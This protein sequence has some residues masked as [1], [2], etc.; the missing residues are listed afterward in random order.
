MLAV[1]T[2]QDD[3]TVCKAARMFEVS[4]ETL[5][6]LVIKDSHVWFGGGR[7]PVLTKDEK[8]LIVVAL[9]KFG[10]KDWPC[11]R[12]DLKLNV[13]NYLDS[14]GKQTRFKNNLPG[15]D[16]FASFRKRCQHRLT[17]RKPEI[18]T[19]GRAK[20]L[21]NKVVKSFF[22]MVEAATVDTGIFVRRL[23]LLKIA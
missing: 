17:V 18:L 3:Q 15:E 21:T 12:S 6:R 20:G 10:K 16:W 9:E 4:I 2:V 7:S 5:R 14:L 8:E 13:K 22:D 23:A 11:D 19:K 1:K